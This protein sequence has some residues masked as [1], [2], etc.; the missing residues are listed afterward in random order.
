MRII[1]HTTLALAL[2]ALAIAGGCGDDE[3]KPTTDTVTPTDTL[4]GDTLTGDA[5]PGDTTASEFATVVFTIDDSANKTYDAT[6]GLAWKGSFSYDAATN[7]LSFDG[8]WGGPFVLLKDDGTMGDATANDGIWTAAVKVA[9]PEAEVTFEYG[10]IRGSVDG[11]DGSWIWTGT[12]GKVIVPAGSTDTITATGLVIAAFGTIDLRLTLDVSNQGANLDALFQGSTYTDVKV[13]GGAWG[14]NEVAMTDDGTKGDVTAA[15]GIYTFVLSEN[16]GKHDGLLKPGAEAPFVFVLDGVEY[17]AGGAPPAT[18][19]TAALDSGAGFVTT[20]IMNYA[21]GDKNTY[22]KAEG[23]G[24]AFVPPANHV[25]VNFTI[26]DTANKT[27]DAT[28]GLAW[29]GSFNFDATTRVLAFA[30]NWSGPFPM[31]YD[32]GPWSAGGHEPAGATA[33]DNIWGVTVWVSNAAALTFE[34]G[35]IR[36]S[37]AGSDGQWI[38]TGSNGGFTVAAGATEAINAAGL[39]IA[40]HGTTDMKLVIDVTNNGA[41]LA[42]LFQ[43]LDYTGKVKVKGSAWGWTEI[44]LNDDGLMGDETSGDKKYTFTLSDKKGKHDGLLSSGA[45]PEFVF[46]LDGIEYKDAGAAA[47]TG[48]TAFV[49]PAAGAWTAATIEVSTSNNNTFITAP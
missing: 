23:G 11:S 40:A 15:D 31:L 24:T 33:G 35:A 14:W 29:K 19:A 48:I 16:L 2:G 7:V 47:A 22:V 21:D 39:V 10:A 27:Y 20:T 43:G 44:A 45:K 4:T 1:K 41:N 28:D 12:N 8:S 38:W 5:T 37:V 30:G 9:K 25:A 49:K 36:G 17:K 32:D 18:G 34:Y 26:N 42:T 3:K 13:K 46:V 6:D